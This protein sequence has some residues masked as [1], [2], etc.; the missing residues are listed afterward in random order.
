MTPPDAP[1]ALVVDDEPQMLDIVT[2]ALETQ[3]FTATTAGTAEAAWAIFRE[4]RFDLLVLDVMLPYASGLGLC[5]RIREI[6]DVPII[7]LTAR[8]ESSDRVEGLEH[9]ADDYV[10]KPF[11][12]R[13]LALRAEA[14][15]RRSMRRSDPADQAFGPLR[16]EGEQVW[17][18]SAPVSL[19]AIERRVL[20]RLMQAAGAT[21]P[22]EGLLLAGWQQLA[23]PGA[24][25]MLKTTIYRLRG[26]L[27]EAGFNGAVEAV[28]AEGY[29]LRIEA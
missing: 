1:L 12:P 4:Q 27:S 24:R 23:G 8:G 17:V 2:F 22:F 18:A 3:G 6:S 25:Q 16:I 10:T 21:V 5:R 28:R 11:H 26:R 13:E 9:G 14:L 20:A 15:V 19:S 7:L 29:R